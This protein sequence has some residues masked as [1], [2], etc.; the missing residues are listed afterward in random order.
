LEE[1]EDG[2]GLVGRSARMGR[3]CKAAAGGAH[4]VPSADGTHVTLADDVLIP[5]AE[6]E[7]IRPPNPPAR[8]QFTPRAHLFCTSLIS[9]SPSQEQD[10][11]CGGWAQASPRHRDGCH[12]AAAAL[13]LLS[14]GCF[15]FCLSSEMM[16][17]ASGPRQVHICAW[18]K[19]LSL[20]LHQQ[21]R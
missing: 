10:T 17:T 7:R 2:S 4:A 12:G 14:V 3:P 6:S 16:M 19:A 11:L 8:H 1:A 15:Y 13:L 20:H 5:R 18:N 9:G 21:G